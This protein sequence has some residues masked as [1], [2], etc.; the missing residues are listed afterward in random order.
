MYM[1]V[2]PAH[3]LCSGQ[4]ELSRTHADLAEAR[5]ELR[6]VK[7]AHSEQEADWQAQEG[8]MLHVAALAKGMCA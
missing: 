2:L 1:R 4:A 5:G 8:R 6:R 3:V 7:V